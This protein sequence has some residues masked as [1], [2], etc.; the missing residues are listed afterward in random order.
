MQTS[1]ASRRRHG[2]VVRVRPL[3]L[4]LL[5]AG[6]ASASMA[7]TGQVI[8]PRTLPDLKNARTVGSFTIPDPVITATSAKQSITQTSDKG[9]IEIGRSVVNVDGQTRVQTRGLSVGSAAWIDVTAP[10][11]NSLTVFRSVGLDPSSIYGKITANDRLFIINPNGIYVG[12]GASISASSL[13]VSALD[14]DPAYTDK[15]YAKLFSDTHVVFASGASGNVYGGGY[16][17]PVVEIAKGATL[18]ATDGGGV[19]LIGDQGVRNQGAISVGSGG[20]ISLV[21]AGNVEVQIGDSGYIQLVAA[22]APNLPGGGADNTGRTIVNTGTLDAPNGNVT[23]WTVGYGFGGNVFINANPGN[24]NPDPT[25]LSNYLGYKVAPTGVFN[26]GT[27]T[28]NGVG[29]LNGGQGSVTM[30]AQGDSA[31]VFNSGKVDVSAKDAKSAAGSIL[32]SAATVV[33]GNPDVEATVNAQLLADGPSGGGSI[34]INNAVATPSESRNLIQI[35]PAATLS[36]DATD[37]GNGGAIKLSTLDLSG[38]TNPAEQFPVGINT[39]PG[40]LRVYGTLQARGGLNGG[41]GGS[42]ETSGSYV[43]VHDV[44]LGQASILVGARA[45]GAAGGLW[46][47][48]SPT[49]TI[50]SAVP[51]QADGTHQSDT[52]ISAV[53]IN[54]VLNSG[55]SVGMST[56]YQNLSQVSSGPLTIESGT[57]ILQSAGLGGNSLY[58]A[59]GSDL[60]MNSG[61]SIQSTSGT[62]GISLVAD[63]YGV[64]QGS[65]ILGGSG[66]IVTPL[67][68]KRQSLAITAPEGGVT[69][70]TNGADLHLTGAVVPADGVQPVNANPGV[71]INGAAIST[72][73]HDLQGNEI[74]GNVLIKG[75]GGV[76]GD[77]AK[78]DTTV[79]GQI[80]V[81]IGGGT[82][83]EAGNANILGNSTSVAGVSLS[84]TTI[85]TDKG[86]IDIRGV[87]QGATAAKAVGTPIGVDFGSNVIINAG[88]GYVRILGRGVREA[89]GG[90]AASY[91]VRANDLTVTTNGP[92]PGQ[93]ITIIGQSGGSAGAGVQVDGGSRGIR[94]F[95]QNSQV[96]QVSKPDVL[97]ASSAD[98]IIGASADAVAPQA[99]NLGAPTFYT[100]GRINVRPAGVSVVDG[101]VTVTESP[102]TAIR[103]GS[104][105]GAIATNFIVKPAWFN[106][107]VNSKISPGAVTVIGSS[108]QSGQISVEAGALN[109]AG[110]VTLQNQGA[111]SGGI[112]LEAQT[113]SNAALNLALATTGD[114]SQSGPIHVSNLKVIAD[115]GSSVKLND[116][117]N[118]IANAIFNN[119][120]VTPQ[121]NAQA[122]PQSNATA[123]A[124]GYSVSADSANG[125]VFLPLAISFEAQR[126]YIPPEDRPKLP[127]ESVDALNELRTDVYLHGQF[128]RP[129]L[130]T[131]TNT[132]GTPTSDVAEVDPLS[133]EWTKVRRGAQLTNCSG[134]QAEGSCSAF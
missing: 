127:F 82:T 10:T 11:V 117:G 63:S 69:I 17:S 80:G 19:M 27:I 116:P 77:S 98:V 67:S 134:V 93:Q 58:L 55:G 108:A 128:S 16:G 42:V 31:V 76:A 43:N 75:A 89:G 65:L 126:V 133:L 36:A 119:K 56:S 96:N 68:I 57:Q 48:Y 132:A 124:I 120:V 106:A 79:P 84:N 40:D 13:V 112:S 25:G 1:F 81:A 102:T 115:A 20:D 34:T 6:Y 131:P 53:D 12:S 24:A 46:T 130:C 49:L 28:A 70:A 74:R 113:G 103:V 50:G 15:D 107:A 92:N 123:S 2:R 91:G 101:T 73:G 104:S 35:L 83:I 4:A 21:A 7:L 87:S 61:A 97:V 60:I 51:S 66:Q 29:G 32:L 41:N 47:V 86:V 54:A 18:T 109:G 85:S 94:L 23:L 52:Y 33:V 8:D 44:N 100:N 62:L 122:L 39:H 71:L 78:L 99:L 110:T 121:I 125:N 105:A 45:A 30:K 38:I 37:N 9:V 72:V 88:Q 26:A 22:T 111:G 90:T 114:I 129:Q 5:A 59:S 64:G 95:D 14:L 118:Q 3:M